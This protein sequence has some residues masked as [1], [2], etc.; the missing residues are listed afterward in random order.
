[1]AEAKKET[2]VTCKARLSY[3][4]L[5]DVHK[6][7]SGKEQYDC[8]LIVPKPATVS[9]PAYKAEI[10]AMF[11]SMQRVIQ[12]AIEAQWGKRPE[13]LNM[14]IK[15]GD[16]KRPTDGQPFDETVHGAF[17]FTAS[18]GAKY[19]PSLVLNE[20]DNFG[21]WKRAEP[22]D[23]YAGC[24]VRAAISAYAWEWKAKRGVSFNVNSVQKLEDGEPL[25]AR[26]NAEAYFGAAS[27]GTAAGGTTPD[28]IFA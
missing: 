10:E 2:I 26:R 11:A 8:V 22:A 9:D 17:F 27:T 1:M 23:I 25:S 15:D 4:N 21:K 28:S 20:T 3:P 24:Y 14:P 6:T 13:G 5:F 12:A 19:P 7:D 16:G 18:S